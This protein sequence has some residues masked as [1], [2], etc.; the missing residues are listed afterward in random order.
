MI[1]KKP[2]VVYTHKD[3]NHQDSLAQNHHLFAA[4]HRF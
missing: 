1:N 4:E 3:P 2:I